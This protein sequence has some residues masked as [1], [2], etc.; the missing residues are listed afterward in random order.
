VNERIGAVIATGTAADWAER[1]ARAGGLCQRVREIE[2][3]WAD[4]LL[5]ERGLLGRT[6][7]G[8]AL[9]LVSLARGADPGAL[10]L[11][12]VLGEHTD[13]VLAELR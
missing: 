5:A 9:P 4:P 6:E 2:E 1:I 7:D 10:P 13:A 12:P 8:V 11:A 3:A